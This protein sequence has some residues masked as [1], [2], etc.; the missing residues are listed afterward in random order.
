MTS[1]LLGGVCF[2]WETCRVLATRLTTT[3]RTRIAA[4]FVAHTD[5]QSVPATRELQF[6][7]RSLCVAATLLREGKGPVLRTVLA[8]GFAKLRFGRPCC[9]SGVQ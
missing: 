4:I 5:V 9:R 8:S 3:L 1:S 7:L 2:E 6:S